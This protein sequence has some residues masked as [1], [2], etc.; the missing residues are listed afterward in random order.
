[1]SLSTK[2][3]NSRPRYQVSTEPRA[4]SASDLR[5]GAGAC[6]PGACAGFSRDSVS[7]PGQR[8]LTLGRESPLYGAMMRKETTDFIPT[9]S[10][11]AAPSLAALKNAAPR[12][13]PRARRARKGSGT[14]PCCGA[15][16]SAGQT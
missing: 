1:M 12:T 14:E 13:E 11:Q 7:R 8:R 9:A 2:S 4:E 6:G 16:Q 15:R 3:G 10:I 5:A